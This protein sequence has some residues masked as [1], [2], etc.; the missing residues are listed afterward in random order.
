MKISQNQTNRETFKIGWK[1]RACS[2]CGFVAAV[3]DAVHVAAVGRAV[4]DVV[5]ARAVS[6]VALIR[7]LL[8]FV[9]DALLLV[10]HRRRI[11]A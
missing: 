3:D 8:S 4:G 1:P 2:R 9:D 6:V 5:F 11:R 10:F 7:S